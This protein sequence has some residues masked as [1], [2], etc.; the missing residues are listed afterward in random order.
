LTLAAMVRLRTS[1]RALPFKTRLVLA[2]LTAS[3]STML[4]IG[5]GFVVQERIR[6]RDNLVSELITT[7]R[8]VGDHSTASLTFND[9]KTA[10]EALASLKV[11]TA[12]VAAAIVDAQGEIFARYD[13]VNAVVTGLP[14]P[15]TEPSA[16][17]EGNYLDLVE[18][19]VMDGDV[20]GAV[21]IR[22]SLREMNEFWRNFL[23][24]TAVIM[25]FTALLVYFVARRMQRALVGPLEHLTETAYLISTRKDFTVRAKL[26]S[27]DEF[28]TLG[29]AFNAMV[30]TI[31]DR[32]RSLMA[33]NRA[34]DENRLRLQEANE[35]LERRVEV[36]TAE[37]AEMAREAATARDAAEAANQAKSEF[38]ANMSH[39]IRTPMNAIIGMS[40]LALQTDLSAKQRNYIDKAHRAAVNLLG[41][42]NDILDFSKIEAGK[43]DM[44][45]VDFRLEDV[46]DNLANVVGLK[47]ENKGLELLFDIGPVMHAALIGDAL[48]LGQIVLNLSSN[49]VKFTEQGEIVIGAEE[50]AMTED[51]V[52]LH[53]WVK[54]SG[55][56]MSPEQQSRLFQ[57]FSQA[58]GS[59]TRKYGGTG[60]GLVISKQLVEMMGGRIWVES[61]EGKGSAFHFHA[62]FGRQRHPTSRRVFHAEEFKGLRVL[63]ADDNASSREI[64]T[65]MVMSFGMA[66]DTACD[67]Q[68]AWD[69][70]EDA[71]KRSMPFDL[72]LMDWKMPVMNGLDCVRKIQEDP[73]H[74]IPAVIMVTAYGREEAMIA[75]ERDGVLLKAVLS[76]PITPSTLFDAIGEALVTLGKPLE[77]RASVM[78]KLDTAREA[79]KKLGGAKVLLV[80]DNEINQEL[81]LEL[82]SQAR[83]DITLADDGQKALDILAQTTDFDGIL[84]DCQMPVMD[85]Y[86]ATR[87]IRKIPCFKD[88]PIIALTANAM[89]GDKEKAVAA[90]MNDLVAK[91]L[92]INDM[93]NTL[94]KWIVPTKP[95]EVTAAGPAASEADTLPKLPGIDTL[96]G[97]STT[98]GNRKLYLKLLGKF[99]DGHT[100]FETKF[101]A[102]QADSDPSAATRAAHTLKGTAGNLGAR[103]VQDAAS[104]L[105]L[106]CHENRPKEVVDALLASTLAELGPVIAGLLGMDRGTEL[107]AETANVDVAA[108]RPEL[109]RLMML[110]NNDDADAVDLVE[111][112]AK[113]ARGSPLAD[114]LREAKR[115]VEQFDFDVALECLSKA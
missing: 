49:A 10:K 114:V 81:A 50:V 29:R 90:G 59:T 53:F 64:L 57:S 1:M 52:E 71:Q 43:L 54:D 96:A 105:V 91:P 79:M 55:I 7:A 63:V 14:K 77:M 16:S 22:A 89:V 106:A 62:R 103:G 34:L 109:E 104:R 112:L 72:V 67:G 15:A 28:G 48:R 24:S 40:H 111:E 73:S 36:R 18:P 98:M 83:M 37:L 38:L 47:A 68:Q 51:D 107:Q 32:D 65:A 13:A 86:T 74:G 97:L 110:L 92:N 42:I 3:L 26:E 95:L 88:T 102:A 85:G 93:F 58:D 82:L 4:L 35:G 31:E 101:R 44:E 2:M 11:K 21:L 41:I 75:A 27:A 87:E 108:L 12:V 76:K 99:L 46:F 19:I 69:M 17:F 20:L 39:E 45:R 84:M 25:G 61:T 113:K 115:H 80:E 56:G 6:I 30:D 100:D 33:S 70:I 66:V 60:L 78:R 5:A 9:P 23:V 94:A 8:L